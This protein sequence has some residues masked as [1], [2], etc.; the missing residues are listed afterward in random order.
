[1]QIF[2]ISESGI[3]VPRVPSV[4]IPVVPREECEKAKNKYDF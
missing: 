2:V 4:V 1:L 3:Y